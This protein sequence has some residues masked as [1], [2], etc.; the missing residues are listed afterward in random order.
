LNIKRPILAGLKVTHN[1]NL[2]CRHCPF[3]KK[4]KKSLSFLQV[5][6]SL[7]DLYNLGVRIVIIEGGEPFLWKDDGYDIRDV[8]KEAK[9]LFVS[10]GIT[11]NGTF[12][13]GIDSDV[14]WVSIDGLRET[15][16][17][18]RGESFDKIIDNIKNS[19]H[20]KIYAHMTVNKVNQRELSKTVEFLSDKVKGI[21]I[22]FH[23]PYEDTNDELLLSFKERSRVLDEF[24]KMKKDGFPVANSMACLEALKGN[25]WKCHQWM[26]ASVDPDGK[27]TQG[28]YVKG[29]GNVS[30]DKCGFSTH[31]EISLA[32][33]GGI[34]SIQLGREIFLSS[35]N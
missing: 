22:Q 2:R 25:K 5:K 4:E 27:L 18:I 9:K 29:R 34:E 23:Y 14:I 26:I 33:S 15:H 7:R 17:C 20:P 10:V 24:I 16:N 21:T 31:T 1:C 35:K 19:A 28:C 6:K 30:C 3:W 8:V 32:Y 12:P 13:L 11:T